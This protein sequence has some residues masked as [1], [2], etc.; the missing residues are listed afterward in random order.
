MAGSALT[1]RVDEWVEQ[2]SELADHVGCR[3][4]VAESLTG[5]Q[6]AAALASAPSAGD[7][8]RGGI[9]AYHPEVKYGLLESP[10][11]PVVTPETA[12]AMART[13]AE[14]LGADCTAAL[15]GVG[16][17]GP[18]EHQPPGTVFL[19]TYTARGGAVVEGHRFAGDPIEVMTQ[20]I[21]A[22]LSALVTRI[23]IDGPNAGGE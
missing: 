4:A 2:L 18:D 9:V 3:I 17:P 5:G 13:V 8:F 6:L 23:R 14:R 1:P 7:W 22:A 19:A 21:E 15:T 10:R 11:G 16:G 12:E 20:S